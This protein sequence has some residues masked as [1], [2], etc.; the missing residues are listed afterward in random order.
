MVQTV[1][2]TEHF[3][4][5]R[6]TRGRRGGRGSGGNQDAAQG[7]K[8]PQLL[9]LDSFKPYLVLISVDILT[10]GAAGASLEYGSLTL[11]RR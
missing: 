2:V 1:R 9:T 10:S 8:K 5:A 6:Q 3:G 11:E 4:E 7:G